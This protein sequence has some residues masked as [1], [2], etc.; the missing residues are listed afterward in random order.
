MLGDKHTITIEPI[1]RTGDL[2]SMAI[3]ERFNGDFVKVCATSADLLPGQNLIEAA[4]GWARTYGAAF[5]PAA[6]VAEAAL[7]AL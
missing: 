6:A 2:P 5:D 3:V 1:G 4:Q 7:V